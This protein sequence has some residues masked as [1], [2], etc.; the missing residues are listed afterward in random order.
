MV[1]RPFSQAGP[2]RPTVVAPLAR[3]LG[4]AGASH[5]ST[6]VTSGTFRKFI[7]SASRSATR[8]SAATPEH[9]AAHSGP[10]SAK[11]GIVYATAKSSSALRLVERRLRTDEIGR[12]NLWREPR[13]LSTG[14]QRGRV[15][16]ESVY[17]A[18]KAGRLSGSSAWRHIAEVVQCRQSKR[19]LR[20]AVLSRAVRG[21]TRR[22]SGAPTAGR[23]AREAHWCILRLAGLASHRCHP[24]SSNVRPHKRRLVVACRRWNSQDTIRITI[25]ATGRKQ[26]AP[27]T[28]TFN[29]TFR[30]THVQCCIHL[31]TRNIRCQVH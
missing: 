14:V 5:A 6:P 8:N 3:T 16:T 17:G 12:F 2:W 26:S 11:S 9:R 19:S 23:Q 4:P 27:P 22:S 28:H 20:S 24:L 7:R 18:R 31:G 25:A 1:L 21:L 13:Q 30:S 15:R 10:P 29:Q